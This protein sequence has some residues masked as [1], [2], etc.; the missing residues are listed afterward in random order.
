MVAGIVPAMLGVLAVFCSLHRGSPVS[1]P[2]PTPAVV[3]GTGSVASGTESPP[4]G[5]SVGVSARAGTAVAA[6]GDR[7]WWAVLSPD[8][9][10]ARGMDFEFMQEQP[11]AFPEFGEIVRQLMDA[12]VPA[13]IV[14]L[15][16]REILGALLQRRQSRLLSAELVGEA[17]RDE[18]DAMAEANRL[19]AAKFGEKAD[20]A[21]D[22]VIGRLSGMG[23]ARDSRVAVRILQLGPTTPLRP[24]PTSAAAVRDQR[25]DGEPE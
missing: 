21:E 3:G 11:G 17:A 6:V 24:L 16:S 19:L 14:R 1:V 10:A 25:F 23:I 8:E 15:E 2:N 4:S 18:S 12:G 7:P 13:E 9:V 20:G 22:E 5:A